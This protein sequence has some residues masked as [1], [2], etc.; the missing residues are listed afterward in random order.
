[1]RTLDVSRRSG[2]VSRAYA[3]LAT[4]CAA[5][6]VL[7][8]SFAGAVVAI[9]AIAREVGGGP[10]GLNWVVNAF[11]LAFG[12]C[13]MMAGTLADRYGRKR[14]FALGMTS[15]AASSLLIGFSP[16]IAVINLLRAVQGLSAAAALA[17]GAAALAQEFD[18][19]G[20][21]RA[22]SL[23]GTTFGA[24][25]AFG[26]VLSGFLVECLG[27]RSVFLSG[28][29]IGVMVLLFGLPYLRE[30]RDS[31][32][33]R[34]DVGGGLSFTVM[35]ALLTFAVLQAPE[36]GWNH[37][38]VVSSL[39]MSV[40]ALAVFIRVECRGA[41]PMLDLSLFRS[42]LF[43]GVQ[44]LPMATCFC[45][46]VLLVI[47][48]IRFIGIEG[49]SAMQAGLLMIALS[50]PMLFVPFVVSTLALRYPGYLLCC[51]GLV[52]AAA[53]LLLLAGLG[54]HPPVGSLAAVLGM[55]GFGAAMPWGL[56]DGLSVSVVP[57]E[58]AGMATGIFSTVRVAGEGV[59]I[60]V[61][62]AMFT[63]LARD[64]VLGLGAGINAPAADLQS[65][66]QR[67]ATGDLPGAQRL[68]PGLS[69]SDLAGAYAEAFE[70][71]ILTL[72]VLTLASSLAIFLLFSRARRREHEEP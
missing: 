3:T 64:A 51:L 38:A 46:V 62:V 21:T 28:T 35:L 7:P 18:G 16:G 63:W 34:L 67:L 10:V 6:L 32:A 4:V 13:L 45:Y 42:P 20:R 17:G 59:S 66:S 1:M 55:I 33:D 53:G 19:D 36:Y 15:F 8:L 12:S 71:L 50:L 58:R 27:W 37:V 52:W 70:S 31:G 22:F 60:A 23:L 47:L 25:L 61:A 49:Y 5:A 40:A 57:K 43:L 26:P 69:V 72:F 24:G 44:V 41:R 68:L 30:S 11:M 14:I 48:P 65:A 54:L 9:P 56:M 39:A 2:S 29:V